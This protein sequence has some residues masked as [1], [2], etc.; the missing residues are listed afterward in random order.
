MKELFSGITTFLV[1]GLLLASPLIG[2]FA[3][4]FPIML[5]VAIGLLIYVWNLTK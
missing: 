2:A 4:V 5:I 3:L 1:I